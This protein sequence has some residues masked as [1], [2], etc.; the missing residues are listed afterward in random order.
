MTI[1]DL[2]LSGD[3]RTKFAS[4]EREENLARVIQ[5]HKE[6]YVVQN[7][8]GVFRAEVTGNL[9]FSAESRE[10]FPAV[11]DWVAINIFDGDTAIIYQ[12]LPR[13][14]KL[15]RQAVGAYGEKQLIA[16]NIDFAFIVQA[17][18]RDFNLNRL[19]RYFVI[20][21]DGNIEPIVILNKADLLSQSEIDEIKSEVGKRLKSPMI[22]VT[23]TVSGFG[24]DTLKGGLEQ[25][26][27]YCF[28]GSSG[29]GKSSVINYLLGDHLLDVSNIS[30]ST[31]KG[32]HTTTHRELLVLENGGILIDTPGMREVGMIE[33]SSGLELTFSQIKEL[34][35]GC[36][37]TNCTHTDEPGCKVLEAVDEGTISFEE[38]EN[39]KKLERQAE[40]F[41]ATVANR[42]KK[43]RSFGKMAKEI[44][45]HKKKSKY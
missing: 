32:R 28:L 1:E 8:K 15:E 44:M 7:A 21:H 26:R 31:G 13:F 23:S 34:S 2:G 43:D 18:D 17:L 25:G 3:L 30:E 33:S 4:I 29:V 37:F 5:E 11:G 27:T 10:D 12:V 16:T 35:S 41:S 40:H 14:S 45:K 36:K 6:S 20:A 39:F 22:Y 19:E 42:R 24:F 9:R 38:L